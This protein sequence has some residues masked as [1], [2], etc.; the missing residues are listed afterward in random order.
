MSIPGFPQK[1][2]KKM[3][4]MENSFAEIKNLVE[5][6]LAKFIEVRL[7][8]SMSL[9]FSGLRELWKEYTSGAVRNYANLHKGKGSDKLHEQSGKYTQTELI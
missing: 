4:E 6:D 8:L 1:L 7:D 3:S 2:E 5:Q 9:D